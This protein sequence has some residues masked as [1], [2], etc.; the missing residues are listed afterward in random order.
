MGHHARPRDVPTERATIARADP[1]AGLV[2]RE[3]GTNP[4]NATVFTADHEGLFQ[5][6]GRPCAIPQESGGGAS[7]ARSFGADVSRKKT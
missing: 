2:P 3:Q 5:R 7:K 6:E 1:V 4:G